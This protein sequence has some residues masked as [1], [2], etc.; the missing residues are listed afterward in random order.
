MFQFQQFP[1]YILVE[2]FYKDI[3]PII[4]NSQVSPDLRSQLDRAASS[5]MLNIAEGAGKFSYRDKKNF[6]VIARG[7]V[8]ECLAILQVLCIKNVINDGSLLIFTRNL[9]DIARMLTGLIKAMT[10]S[11]KTK[12]AASYRE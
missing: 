8:N 10:K 2:T 1:V 7:S 4:N 6:Y 9:N 3:Q 11:D 12:S 5:I